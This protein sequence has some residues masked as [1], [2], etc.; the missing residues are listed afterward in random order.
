MTKTVVILGA[1]WAGLPLAH[2]LLK[3]TLPKV[4]DLKVILASPNS[5]FFWN[6]A[7][8][9]GIIPDAIPDEQLFL[10]IKPGFNQYPSENFEFLLGKADGV[11]AESSTV[12]V[13]SNENTRREITYD[14]LVIAT[15]S[16]LASDLPLKPVGTHQETISA[17]KQLQSEV[18]DSK[19]IVIAGGGAT[20]T[21]VAGELAA[22]YGSSKSITLVISGAQP[23][24][25]ALGSV[26][27]SISRDLKTLGV[28]LIYNARVTEAKKSERGQGAEVH[29]S[30]GS[31]LTTDL[32]LPLH[33]IKLNTSFVPPSLLDSGGNIKLDGKMRVAGTKNIW[34]IGDVGNIDPKQLT[35]TDNQIIHLATA[36]DATLTKKGDIKPY[37]PATKKMIFVSLG[38]KYATGQIGNWKLFSFMVSYVKGRKLFVDTA[39]GYVGGKHLR[40]A[41]I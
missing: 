38:K 3:H 36:L 39:E 15:G 6:V 26:R 2:K 1:G 13:I 20:G 10:P 18:G 35:I 7:A 11:D 27:A 12:H 24:E 28:R 14:E 23:L 31:T 25:G 22:R 9:R 40:H 8:T 41:A 30:N 5:H 19:S 34:G 4:P 16:R 33:G 29:L 32:Y 21:E 37:Q 17:W